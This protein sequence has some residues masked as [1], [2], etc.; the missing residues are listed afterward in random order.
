[1][2]TKIDGRAHM[3]ALS[4]LL[5]VGKQ[6]EEI[7]EETGSPHLLSLPTARE[8]KRCI[9]QHAGTGPHHKLY[10]GHFTP[11]SGLQSALATRLNFSIVDDKMA[12]GGGK[13]TLR[14]GGISGQPRE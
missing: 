4:H 12:P 2:G 9:Q 10:R 6:V 1:M 11:G 14:G 7:M 13:E 5:K 3:A 8:R